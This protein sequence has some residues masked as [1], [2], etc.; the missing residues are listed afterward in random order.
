MQPKTPQ[1]GQATKQEV[2]LAVDP[3]VI[4]YIYETM[5]YKNQFNSLIE[6]Q[7]V[8]FCWKKGNKFAVVKYNGD[9]REQALENVQ[10]FLERVVKADIPKTE[11]PEEQDTKKEVFLA[12]DPDVIAY[13]N[14]TVNYKYQFYSLMQGVEFCWTN[15]K[16]FATI[17]YNGECSKERLTSVLENVQSFLEKFIKSDIPVQKHIW[18][19][20]R[21]EMANY[22]NYACYGQGEDAPKIQI[23][24]EQLKLRVIFRNDTDHKKIIKTKLSKLSKEATFDCLELSDYSKEYIALLKKMEFMEKSV[25]S[26]CKDVEVDFDENSLKVTLKGPR[27][28]LKIAEDEFLEQECATCEKP[29]KLS[30]NVLTFLMTKEGKE[31]IEKVMEEHKCSVIKFDTSVESQVSAKVLGNSD[32]HVI[33]AISGIAAEETVV[34]EECNIALKSRPEWIELCKNIKEKT[35]VMIKDESMPVTLVVGF[36]DDV[37]R[38]FKKLQDF[39]EANLIRKEH[40]FCP[41]GDVKEYIRKI[42]REELRSI[43][44]KLF[45]DDVRILDDEG[46]DDTFYISGRGKGLQRA[47]KLLATIINKTVACIFPIEQP[48]LRKTFERGRGDALVKMVGANQKCI[49]RIENNFTRNGGDI[50]DGGR[51]SF[52]S[53]DDGSSDLTQARFVTPQG[54]TISRKVG[55]I[56][57]E[58][59]SQTSTLKD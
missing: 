27:H 10:L 19:A 13:I 39:V 54:Q 18:N 2:F 33:E 9:Y 37:K 44:T 45:R 57:E 46:E 3:D 30:Q 6:E 15:G 55:N 38:S 14:E 41:S 25:R 20:A 23:L 11:Q 42:R 12:V 1:A 17:K 47:K 58:Q 24:N 34:V 49:V 4:A 51:E 8:E 52:R 7:G 5:N 32:R 35:S 22:A 59:V 43:E 29:L 16:K 28:Q 26:K 36:T 50:F 53:L 48:G 31:A 56:A 21:D 40:L